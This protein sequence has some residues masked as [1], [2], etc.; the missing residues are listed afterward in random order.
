MS[1]LIIHQEPWRL[2][3][4]DCHVYL[5]EKKKKHSLRKNLMFQHLNSKNTQYIEIYITAIQLISYSLLH[6]NVPYN[7]IYEAPYWFK[8]A[9]NP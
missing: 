3:M 1:S 7:H 2:T 5:K 9:K 6:V 4:F 8:V